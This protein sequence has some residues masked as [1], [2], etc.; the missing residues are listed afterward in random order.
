[1][2]WSILVCVCCLLL[3]ALLSA[4][5]GWLWLVGFGCWLVAL[6]GLSLLYK[7]KASNQFF[8]IDRRY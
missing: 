6:F 5:V 7:I 8:I 4:K 3:V 1:M 2:Y